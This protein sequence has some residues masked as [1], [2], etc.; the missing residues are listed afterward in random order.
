MTHCIGI[1][2]HPTREFWAMND[3][4]EFVISSRDCDAETFKKWFLEQL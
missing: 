2:T 4:A 1:I 3:D